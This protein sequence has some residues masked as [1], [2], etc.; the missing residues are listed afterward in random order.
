[1]KNT[2]LPIAALAAAV[3]GATSADAVTPVLPRGHYPQDQR[4]IEQSW[5]TEFLFEGSCTLTLKNKTPIPCRNARY[6][7]IEP[8]VAGLVAETDDGAFVA[9]GHVKFETDFLKSRTGSSVATLTGDGMGLG[10]RQ[11]SR[12]GRCVVELTHDLR[13]GAAASCTA[14]AA[15]LTIEA[16][17]FRLLQPAWD[18]RFPALE[19]TR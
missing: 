18:S 2:A 17:S 3:I 19:T 15:T 11:I 1:M 5:P 10:G 14:D 13:S 8:G 9:G 7:M 12:V 4:I 6:R 16:G